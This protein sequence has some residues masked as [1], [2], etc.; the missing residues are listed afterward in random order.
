VTVA[1][2]DILHV[3]TPEAW[4]E[5]RRRGAV[6]PP[7]LDREGFVHCSTRRQLAATLA[8]HFA[9]AGPLVALVVDREAVAADLRWAESHPGEL[10]PHVHAPIPVRAIVAV[11]PV[12]APAG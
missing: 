8:R 3:T 9:G 2:D 1:D 12:T 4:E 6:H 10:F 11:E 5:A 7:S